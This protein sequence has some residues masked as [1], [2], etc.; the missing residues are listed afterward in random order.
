MSWCDL[1][2]FT[3]LNAVDIRP[4]IFAHRIICYRMFHAYSRRGQ[5]TFDMHN[6]PSVRKRGGP[7]TLRRQV[8]TNPSVVALAGGSDPIKVI[9]DRA[10]NLVINA[11]EKGWSGPPYDPFILAEFQRVA[12]IAREDIP[13]ARTIPTKGG[14][15]IEY[16]PNQ[17]KSRVKYSICHELAHTLF[18]DCDKR[19]RNRVTH[20]DTKGDEWQLET[21]CN[22]GAA[23]MLMPI[24]STASIEGNRLTIDAILEAR[25]QHQVSAEAV[26]LRAIRLTSDQC[27]AFSS[28]RRQLPRQPQERYLIDYIVG[29]RTWMGAIRAGA[30]LPVQTSARECIAIGFTHKGHE[31][32]DEVGPVRVEC[33]GVAPYPNQTV[34]RV[35][36]IARP[37]KQIPVT[38]PGITDVRGDASSP[39]GA[40]PNILAQ[41]VNDS[42]FTW[43]GGFSLTV[44]KKWPEAQRAF[45]EWAEQEPRNLKLGNVHM[46]DANDNLTVVSL[47]AQHGYG[48]SPKPRIRYAALEA[49][50]EKLGKF[51]AAR[52]AQ[53]HMPRI[54]SGQAG[55][56]WNII[57]EVIEDKVCAQGVN[58]VV[59]E[60]PTG[61]APSHPQGHLEFR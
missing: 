11:I 22:I 6:E 49:C 48:P 13:D 21:L 23:E 43:G 25:K 27:C 46:S 39:R 3:G 30:S 57:R 10:R 28:S 35:L 45:R 26:L 32:W 44:R 61:P 29:S 51:A 31:T 38:V 15:T 60:P 1:A 36:G 5:D 12:V 40:G 50:L 42:A 34:P 59:Y 58:V 7:L 55:G 16:N 9:T 56:S 33:L 37:Q 18:P 54:G 19:I 2:D 4:L 41:I 53:V 8:W 14:Y 52:H 47:I 24:G 20:R 17:P